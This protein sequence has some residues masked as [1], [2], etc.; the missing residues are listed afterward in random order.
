MSTVQAQPYFLF[1]RE[2][3]LAALDQYTEGWAPSTQA[4]L[5]DSLLHFLD[6]TA[7][8]EHRLVVKPAPITVRENSV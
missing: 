7:A 5:R 6:S 1:S 3:L 4:E 2:Q 8:A